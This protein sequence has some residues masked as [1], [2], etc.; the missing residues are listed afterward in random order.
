MDYESKTCRSRLK[1][2]I[3]VLLSKRRGKHHLKNRWV[4]NLLSKELS[5]PQRSVLSK[6]LNFASAP[7][8]IPIPRVVAAT[9]DGLRS[10][11]ENTAA[12]IRQK[13]IGLLKHAKPQS[14]NLTH[15]LSQDQDLVVLPAD[16][17]KSTVVMDRPKYDEKIIALFSDMST[18]KVLQNDPTPSLQ[19]K[20][21]SELLKLKKN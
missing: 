11:E 14:D 1:R 15:E 8:K 20:M 9:E 12:N 10:V 5:D 17:G 6:G 19:R 7:L 13:V 18:Y 3:E 4:V 2:K 21:I 16:K